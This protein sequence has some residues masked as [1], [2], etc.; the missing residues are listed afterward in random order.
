MAEECVHRPYLYDDANDVEHYGDP[1]GKPA[2][3]VSCQPHVGALTCAEHKCRCAY[4]IGET[5]PSRTLE[6]RAPVERQRIVTW[7][8]ETGRYDNPWNLSDVADAIERG[9]HMS[10]QKT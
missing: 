1:C 4:A 8:R 7:L 2:T 9:E 3:H 10:G 5:P 6:V